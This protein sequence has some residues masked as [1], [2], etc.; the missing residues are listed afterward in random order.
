M[1][2]V[3]TNLIFHI[4]STIIALSHTLKKIM[5]SFGICET[6]LITVIVLLL[7]AQQIIM[8]CLWNSMYSLRW[9]FQVGLA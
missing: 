9:A 8:F 1:I 4:L 7:D 5:Q 3:Y 6:D 2:S